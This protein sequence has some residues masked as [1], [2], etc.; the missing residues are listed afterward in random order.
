MFST[1]LPYHVG[2]EEVARR[3]PIGLILSGGPASVYADGAPKLDPGLLELGI[4]VLGICYGMQLIAREL[5]GTV[6]GAEVGEYGRSQLKVHNRGRLLAETPTEQACWMS[7]RDTVFEAPPGL[8]RW[9]HR[10]PRRWLRLSPR[11][12]TS[13][14]SS[15]TLR[16]C[17]RPMGSRCCE[18]PDRYLRRC[19][20]L[21]RALGD[22]G[23][24]RADPRAGR[25][26]AGA[27]RAVRWGRFE[28]RGAARPQGDR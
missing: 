27:V 19:R 23:A 6:E 28:R 12:A 15:F 18:L 10:R 16:S 13:T 9:R 14:A 26:W 3:R 21:E 7:H 24:G 1:L 22:R 17:T 25:R 4:P 20:H 11:I 5:G 8:R 2:P